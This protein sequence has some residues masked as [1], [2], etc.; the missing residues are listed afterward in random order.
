MKQRKFTNRDIGFH[1][2]CDKLPS[3]LAVIHFDSCINHG[4]KQAA[5]FLQRALG[6]TDDGIIGNITLS[7]AA[8]LNAV[9]LKTVALS[10]MLQRESFFRNLVAKRPKDAVFLKG[11]LSRVDYYRNWINT[12]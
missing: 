8:S 7:K 11:W 6:V 12:L 5:K 3:M 1:G 2:K 9:Q 10:Y 4:T